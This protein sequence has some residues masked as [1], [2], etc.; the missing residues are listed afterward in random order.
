MVDLGDGKIVKFRPVGLVTGIVVKE[1]PPGSAGASDGP[2][3]T[4]TLRSLG[5]GSQQAAAGDDSRITG[6]A[7]KAANLSD[8]ASASTARTNLGLGTAAV[9]NT[10]TASGQVPV[11]NTNGR[12]DVAR[13]GSG[14]PDGT[15]YLRD[16]GTFATPAGGGGGGGAGALLA[17]AKVEVGTIST[18]S[19]SAVAVNAAFTNTFTV[20][21]SGKVD[22]VID[23]QMRTTNGCIAILYL[24]SGASGTTIIGSGV[25]VS[26]FMTA[27]FR[28]SIVIPVDTLTPGASQTLRLAWQVSGG[29]GTFEMSTGSTNSNSALM[30]T[31]AAL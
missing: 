11:L 9:A 6:A 12:L 25:N 28:R 20:P 15:K 14:T 22:V 2:P 7:Q 26:Y 5:T 30:R 13:L 27:D 4:P 3:A 23:A 29:T 1:G 16:D 17:R 19:T 31:F 18:T 10:G 8:L 21:T 24:Y